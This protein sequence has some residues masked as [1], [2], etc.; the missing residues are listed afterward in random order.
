MSSAVLTKQYIRDITGKPIGVILPIE[1]YQA[2]VQLQAEPASQGQ[3][4]SGASLYG[5][6]RHLGGGVAPTETLDE[7]RRELWST[8]NHTDML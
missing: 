7:T 4:L 5:V 1:E 2:L 6:L 8:W 3:G